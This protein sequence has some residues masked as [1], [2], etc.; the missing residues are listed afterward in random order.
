MAIVVIFIAASFYII[1][2]WQ[3]KSENQ[4]FTESNYEYLPDNNSIQTKAFPNLTSRLSEDIIGTIAVSNLA[5]NDDGHLG[6]P[7]LDTIESL[8]SSAIDG[9]NPADFLP[10]IKDSDLIISQDNSA[11]ALSQYL[12]KLQAAVSAGAF[13]GEPL[14]SYSTTSE[15]LDRLIYSYRNTAVAVQKIS[16]PVEL[17]DLH[18]QEITLLLG[19]ATILEKIKQYESDPL[20]ALLALKSDAYFDAELANLKNDF[21]NLIAKRNLSL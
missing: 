5:G 20:L 4:F 10:L 2:R 1:G 14:T 17:K 11:S 9:F 8:T 18:R 12:S 19:K 13:L 15:A 6:V 16:V 7:S 21:N 3:L